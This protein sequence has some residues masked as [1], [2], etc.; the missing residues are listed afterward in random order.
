MSKRDDGRDP[1]RIHRETTKTTETVTVETETT[2]EESRDLQT[3]DR[4]ELQQESDAVI[5]EE[6]SRDI[7]LSIPPCTTLPLAPQTSAVITATR[8]RPQP[9][10]RC[11][12]PRG[13]QQ[14]R[15]EGPG[16]GARAAHGGDRARGRGSKQAGFDNTKGDPRHPGHLSLA[17]QDLPCAGGELR[18]ANDVRVRGA[19]TVSVLSPCARR[20]PPEGLTLERPDPPGYCRHPS[21]T[22]APLVPGD[23]V[24]SN[25]QFWVSKYGVTGVEPPPSLHRAIGITL[26]DEPADGDSFVTIMNNELTVPQG[27]SRRAGLGRRRGNIV[28]VSD[29]DE[30]MSFHVGRTA[31]TVNSSGPMNG[32]DGT[33]PVV[34][35]G[36]SVAAVAVTIQGAGLGRSR[37]SPRGRWRPIPR[38]SGPIKISITRTNCAGPA[39]VEPP[40]GHRGRRD[41]TPTRIAM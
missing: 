23:L 31:I 17:R 18:A 34:G 33:I 41:G 36:Y 15:Q 7:A 35:H 4:F 22:F 21:G 32:E 30:F 20:T 8:R 5:E 39:R 38:S 25:Y 28:D 37:H 40:G 12:R 27:L 19:G 14:G 26:S 6:S 29:P 10:T 16:A 9:R 1:Q 11:I 2:R 13:D 24:E 3:T